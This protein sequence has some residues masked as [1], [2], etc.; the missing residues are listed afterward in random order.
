M[1]ASGATFVL[2]D[3]QYNYPPPGTGVLSMIMN[4]GIGNYFDNTGAQLV[5]VIVVR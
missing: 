1:G 4:D 2:G 3:N 5:R